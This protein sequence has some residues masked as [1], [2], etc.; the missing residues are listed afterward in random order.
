MELQWSEIN[1]SLFD[2]VSLSLHLS[3]WPY[4]P[5]CLWE[6]LNGVPL[7]LSLFEPL[8]HFLSFFSLS[9]HLSRSLLILPRPNTFA[10]MGLINDMLLIKP[11]PVCVADKPVHI[12]FSELKSRLKVALVSSDHPPTSSSS[13]PS[14]LS[15]SLSLSLLPSLNCCLCFRIGQC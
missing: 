1:W 12:S 8:S 11:Y 13:Y 4:S 14:S 6:S 5:P 10:P 9:F 7:S 2:L 15:L 3:V